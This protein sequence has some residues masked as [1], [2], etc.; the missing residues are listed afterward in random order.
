ML[1]G[2]TLAAWRRPRTSPCSVPRWVE[3]VTSPPLRFR[4]KSLGDRLG[5][6]FS[7]GRASLLAL[8]LVTLVGA[9]ACSPDRDPSNVSIPPFVSN[10]LLAESSASSASAVRNIARLRELTGTSLPSSTNCNDGGSGANQNC[11]IFVTGYIDHADG[12]GGMFC[13][14]PNYPAV[15]D[16]GGTI[17]KPNSVGSGN[18]GRWI[19]ST[20]GS[21]NVRWFG[22]TG[23]GMTVDAGAIQKAVRAAEVNGGGRVHLPKGTYLFNGTPPN[24]NDYVSIRGDNISLSGDGDS[25]VIKIQTWASIGDFMPDVEGETIEGFIQVANKDTIVQ[26]VRILNLRI[27]GPH[28]WNS[29]GPSNGVSAI[30][31]GNGA[32][33]VQVDDSG[34]DRVHIEKAGSAAIAF[35]GIVTRPYVRGCTV[36]NTASTAIRAWSSGAASIVAGAEVNGNIFEMTRGVAIDWAGF[37]ATISDNIFKSVRQGAVTYSQDVS[38]NCWTVISNNT[39]Y[40]VGLDAGGSTVFPAIRLGIGPAHRVKVSGN[41][42]H[43]AHGQGIW[44]SGGSIDVDISQNVIDGFG[45]QGAGRTLAAGQLWSGIEAWGTS[46]RISMTGNSV[47]CYPGSPDS[48][49][50]EYGFV[51]LALVESFVDGNSTLGSYSTKP[52]SIQAT[53]LGVGTK[54]RVGDTNVDIE[55]GNPVSGV[56][57]TG[58]EQLPIL[59]EGA[60]KSVAGSTVWLEGESAPTTIT[61]LND[62]VSGRSYTFVMWGGSAKVTIVKSNYFRLASDFACPGTT[63]NWETLTM[64]WV[65]AGTPGATSGGMWVEDSR[66]FN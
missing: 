56:N 24:R 44:V 52:F 31:F 59:P 40:D 10:P 61:A 54:N 30:Q 7:Q 4:T 25:T 45:Y 21:F 36:E 27:E 48:N 43:K 37:C 23:N 58:L 63:C 34:A 64:T 29:T 33:G 47:K 8:Q 42:V 57:A 5:N 32:S 19:R 49:R 13:Y 20:D 9:L 11:C 38:D 39:I 26:N 6:I 55:S 66:S 22:A 17:I 53:V 14:K 2:K 50:C 65:G 3:D 12:G 51:A 15:V 18:P 28:D 60:T 62:A 41:A 16:N 1:P 46:T 35:N